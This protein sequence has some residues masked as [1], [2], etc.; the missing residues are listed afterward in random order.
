MLRPEMEASFVV[1]RLPRD[2]ARARDERPTGELMLTHV[3][4]G[5]VLHKDII[6]TVVSPMAAPAPATTI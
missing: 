5:Q 3:L 1:H 4:Y 2:P 6:N